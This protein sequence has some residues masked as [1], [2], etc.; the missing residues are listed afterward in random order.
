MLRIIEFYDIVL[1]CLENG[2]L[3]FTGGTFIH[4]EFVNP[5]PFFM[6]L[7]F[8]FRTRQTNGPLVFIRWSSLRTFQIRLTNGGHLVISATGLSN[9]LPITDWLVSNVSIADGH[10]H[11]VRFV[12]TVLNSN[13]ATHVDALFHDALIEGNF[14]SLFMFIITI[15]Q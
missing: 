6:E 5:N 8:S 12:L 13:K 11:R 15:S 10:W 7:K 3:Q 9:G 1:I 2:P 14:T 4:W